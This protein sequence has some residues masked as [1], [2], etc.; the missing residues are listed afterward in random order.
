M[1]P[2]YRAVAPDGVTIG[3]GDSSIPPFVMP[4]SM[5]QMTGYTVGSIY[6]PGAGVAMVVEPY[7]P[8]QQ[9][10]RYYVQQSFAKRCSGLQV[11]G[12]HDLAAP[13]QRINATYAQYGLPMQISFGDVQFTCQSN[14]RAISGYVLAGTQVAQMQGAGIWNVQYLLGYFAPAEHGAEAAAALDHAAATFQIDQTW[15]QRNG[16]QMVAES[17]ALAKSEAQIESIIA[18]NEQNSDRVYNAID[19]FDLHAVRGEQDVVDPDT[20]TNYRVG[21]RYEYNWIDYQGHIVGSDTDASPGL[22]F[23]RLTTLPH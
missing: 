3:A 7:M 18:S 5:L 6:R 23:R 15:A 17:H 2:T 1:R 9:F 8:G 11:T 14:G 21:D 12:S 10:A 16:Q 19:R 22:D 13:S 4:N 20:G